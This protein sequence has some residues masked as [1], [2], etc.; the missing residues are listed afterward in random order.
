MEN[1]NSGSAN[2]WV[3]SPSGS[4][5]SSLKSSASSMFKYNESKDVISKKE[6]T[7]VYR[8]IHSDSNAQVVLKIFLL[9]AGE[10][11]LV[12]L[13]KYA[14]FVKSL[15]HQSIASAREYFVEG[16]KAT[17]AYD[18]YEN[19]S[20][21]E[22][23][24]KFKLRYDSVL[25]LLIG[26][27]KGLVYL[28]E[29]RLVHGNLTSQNVLLDKNLHVK[30]INMRLMEHES[31]VLFRAIAKNSVDVRW[32]APELMSINP[33][34]LSSADIYSFG[35]IMYHMVSLKL[36]YEGSLSQA[37]TVMEV[38]RG[39]RDTV[40]QDLCPP[41]F[42]LLMEQCWHQDE[43]QRPKASDI[44]ETL[45]QMLEALALPKKI[46]QSRSKSPLPFES[47][48][49]GPLGPSALELSRIASKC[50]RELKKEFKEG[51]N[52]VG[53]QATLAFRAL[54][55]HSDDIHGICIHDEKII[56]GSKDAKV[57]I[58]N[59]DGSLIESM[60]DPR[61]KSYHYWVTALDVFNDGSFL[62]GYRNG[63]LL[64]HDFQR[65]KTYYNDSFFQETYQGKINSRYKRRNN[66]RITSVKTL[67]KREG[68]FSFI[69]A[70]EKFVLFNCTTGEA[71]SSYEFNNGDWVYGFAEI[72]SNKTAVIHAASVTI[73]EKIGTLWNK[74]SLIKEKNRL[75][76]G[77]RPFVSAI[78]LF[79]GGN[80][81][82]AAFF[83]GMSEV[84]D[85]E[86]AQVVHSS[87]EHKDRVWEA[88]P[89]SQTQY[90]TCSDD[91]TIKLWDIR[92]PGSIHTISGHPGRVSS[93]GFFSSNQFVAGTCPDDVL[94]SKNKAQFYF[95][96]LRRN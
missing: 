25:K 91:K 50:P 65:R 82:T 59:K 38:K 27:A 33:V 47:K 84:V 3:S 26:I 52:E 81:L 11:N 42:S 90:A 95:Y 30:L 32:L 68:F 89:F 48:S 92:T 86:T 93:L 35:L 34:F 75:P 88:T 45:S 23:I 64:C 1:K 15:R 73:F 80:H 39:V 87:H 53:C 55:V 94:T 8:A 56:S 20:L 51:I 22:Y 96:D 61:K 77:G 16:D 14:L 44:V 67:R 4:L 83:G 72:N 9:S 78:N 19:R 79:H 62:A 57:S 49:S 13:H 46:D 85:V 28:H 31:L 66:F 21:S 54:N 36:P 76:S 63:H 71:S 37:I 17:I 24:S 7:R 2:A 5:A 12:N 60:Y 6:S 58:F 70:P 18:Y 29:R 10:V 41:D 74:T 69:G 43:K 40:A